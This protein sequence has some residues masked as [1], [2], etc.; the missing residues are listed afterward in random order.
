MLLLRDCTVMWPAAL[1]PPDAARYCGV[2]VS[3]LEAEARA[4]RAPAPRQI[5]ARRVVWLRSDLDAWLAK[6]PASTILP[7]PRG[8]DE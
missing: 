2:S 1:P 6:L 4:Q 8:G 7:P 5:S 3:T